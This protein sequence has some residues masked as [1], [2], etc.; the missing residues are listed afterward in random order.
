M[1]IENSFIMR[2]EGM[3]Q[4]HILVYYDTNTGKF[5]T[6][7]WSGYRTDHSCQYEDELKNFILK[8]RLLTQ[9]TNGTQKW[10]SLND[11]DIC[12]IGRGFN[13]NSPTFFLCFGFADASYAVF[14]DCAMN[15]MSTPL[16]ILGYNYAKG[17]NITSV[18]AY[19]LFKDLAFR[20]WFVGMLCKGAELCKWEI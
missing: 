2:N 16:F 5:G 11:I 3:E 1:K 8:F 10:G 17:V 12:L 19:Y 6:K 13:S 9:A 18:F 20:N 7:D 4:R 14:L 15:F